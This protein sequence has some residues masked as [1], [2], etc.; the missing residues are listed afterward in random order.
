MQS[1]NMPTKIQRDITLE[2]I[3]NMRYEIP[4]TSYFNI[5]GH[6][7]SCHPIQ[8]FILVKKPINS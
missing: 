4:D 6:G 8:L 2:D 7:S 1:T 5:D 3:S